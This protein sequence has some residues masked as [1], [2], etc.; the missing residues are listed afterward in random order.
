ML[1]I[2]HINRHYDW[3]PVPADIEV[4]KEH[5]EQ[6]K[7]K[8]DAGG[9]WLAR[10]EREAD[11]H[12][13]IGISEDEIVCTILEGVLRDKIVYTRRRAAVIYVA[14][15]H[16]PHHAHRSWIEAFEIHDDGP[17]DAEKAFFGDRV[18]FFVSAGKI[19]SQDLAELEE[20]YAS[21]AADRAE[22]HEALLANLHNHFDVEVGKLS[23]VR[24]RKGLP[25]HAS[26]EVTS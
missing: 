26:T 8:Q 7:V 5:I 15:H 18:K 11:T 10:V 21:C 17:T 16:M 25:V 20:A 23:E 13:E 14:R 24:A 19:P 22:R 1:I 2:A 4:T 9:G 3:L 6:Q 12:V